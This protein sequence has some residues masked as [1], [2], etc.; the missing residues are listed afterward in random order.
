MTVGAPTPRQRTWAAL[1]DELTP[2]QSLQRLDAA[3]ARVVSNVSVVA[4]LL[5]GLGLVAAGLTD[6]TEAARVL[7]VATV[8]LA[9]LAML[10]ALTAQTLTVTRGL[11]TNNL[12][13]VED[14]YIKRFE[15][16]APLTS[17]ASVLLALAAASA[18]LAAI[19][20]LTEVPDRPTFAVVRTT[21]ASTPIESP[22]TA[23]GN[24]PATSAL[25]V[26]V[27]FPGLDVGEVATTFVTVD[28][29]VLADAAFSA[30]PGGT[31]TRT[32]TINRVPARGV[33]AVDAR[34]GSVGCTARLDPGKAAVVR[35]TSPGQ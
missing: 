5:T 31:T 17:A 35:C 8:G 33:I 25:T 28:G 12:R 32:L 30:G 19:L 27:A 1:A 4:T 11:N 34:A 16:R 3:T 2:A 18:G 26:D 24:T 23:S 13:E 7:A 6:L 20:I 10:L 22:A 9:F 21:E 29:T 15:S 14:W